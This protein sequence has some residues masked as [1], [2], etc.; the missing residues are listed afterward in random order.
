MYE[1]DLFI[2][3]KSRWRAVL[4]GRQVCSN[5]NIHLQ[6]KM[7]RGGQT[8]KTGKGPDT[9]IHILFICEHLHSRLYIDYIIMLLFM[10]FMYE[11]ALRVMGNANSHRLEHLMGFDYN[12]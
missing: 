8:P 4:A 2:E 9:S 5:V 11:G 7:K 1:V 6:N 10:K 3:V 12:L